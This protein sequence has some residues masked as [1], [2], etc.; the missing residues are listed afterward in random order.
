M[1]V[2]NHIQSMQLCHDV[3]EPRRHPV[4]DQ[5]VGE[6][7]QIRNVLK[8]QASVCC[9]VAL[10]SSTEPIPAF[11][12]VS[13]GKAQCAKAFRPPSSVCH[14]WRL[15]EIIHSLSWTRRGIGA[16]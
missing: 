13:T 2:V 5:V 7:L 12:N 11:V 14:I 3:F 15:K 9:V 6:G 4:V 1:V 8:E 16:L 10:A